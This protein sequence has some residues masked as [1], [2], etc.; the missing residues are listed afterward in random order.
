MSLYAGPSCVYSGGFKG[1]GYAPRRL[2][3][4]PSGL[5]YDNYEM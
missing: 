2:A 5:L 3:N 1:G 4:R